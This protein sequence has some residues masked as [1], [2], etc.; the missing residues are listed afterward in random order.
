MS[1]QVFAVVGPSGAGKDTLLAG[2]VQAGLVH[3]V[4]RAITRTPQPGDEPFEGVDHA[5]FERRLR[6]GLFALHW[7]AHGLR[8]GLPWTEFAP[9]ADRR[10]VVFNGSR[11]MLEAAARVFPG[12]RVLLIDAPPALCAR[13]LAARRRE[14]PAQIAA[15]LARETG[16]LPAGLPV[17]RIVNDASPE[18]G[19]ALLRAALAACRQTPA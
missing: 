11:T 17:M 4:R 6:A 16:A 3:R 13:R 2:L 18:Q 14:A 1:A 8:Y 5:E 19:I 12:L 9:L 7:R 10:D 15:R